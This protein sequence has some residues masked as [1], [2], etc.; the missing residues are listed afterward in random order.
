MKRIVALA[1][2]PR[3]SEAVR[4]L[5]ASGR[6]FASLTVCSMLFFVIA[7]LAGMA[8]SQASA[9]PVSSMK[10]FAAAVSSGFFIGLL[11]MELPALQAP[12]PAVA[13]SRAEAASFLVRLLTDVNP[14]DPH[15]LLAGEMPGFQGEDAVLLRGG[16]DVAS[17]P[18]EHQPIPEP[19]AA[20]QPEPGGSGKDG[21]NGNTEDEPADAPSNDGAVPDEPEPA[22]PTA[23]PGAPAKPTTGGRKVVFIYHSHNRESW[24]PELKADAKDPNSSKKNV[25]L[26]GKR[27][28]QRLEANGVGAESSTVDYPT[29]IKDFRWELSYK[30]SKQTVVDAMAENNDFTF[31]FDVHRDSQPRKLTTATINGKDFAQ[32]YFVI[33]NRNPNWRKNE[34]FATK[35]HEALQRKY[36]GISRGVWGKSAKTGNGEYNQ[37][38]S[39]ESV[40]IEIGGVDNTLEESYRTVNVLA[41]VISEIYWEQE[42]VDAQPAAQPV[43]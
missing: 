21:M 10:G 1:A 13:V 35:I 17:A 34:A 41:D 23:E 18:E 29:A 33:G 25:T 5:L 22:G 39:S 42:K 16:T 40:I 30:Y 3:R 24:F 26:V 32:V 20:G 9:S 43:S 11:G 2:G 37:S 27:L 38:L 6:A 31:F 8:H 4:R 12:D 15:S 36:P 28:A 7:G 19:E 14:N